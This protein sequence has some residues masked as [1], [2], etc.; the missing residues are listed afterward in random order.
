MLENGLMRHLIIWIY[1]SIEFKN[2]LQGPSTFYIDPA[3]YGNNSG[4][5]IINGDLEI[6]G[7]TTTINSTIVDISDKTLVLSSNS[8]TKS[9]T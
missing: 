4:K 7:T 6:Q 8:Q 1:Q 3:A 2:V 9:S 5:V